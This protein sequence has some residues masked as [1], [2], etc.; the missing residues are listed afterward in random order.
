M[1]RSAETEEH[2]QLES[3]IRNAVHQISR[4]DMSMSGGAREEKSLRHALAVLSRLGCPDV[5]RAQGTEEWERTKGAFKWTPDLVAGPIIGNGHERD[6]YIDVFQPKGDQY[7]K[8]LAGNP[9]AAAVFTKAFSEHGQFT[10]AELGTDFGSFYGPI[11][12]KL[13][14]YSVTRSHSIMLGVIMY[15]HVSGNAYVGPVLAYWHSLFALDAAFGIERHCGKGTEGSTAQALQA[16]GRETIGVHPC[17]QNSQRD[18]T[19]ERKPR[20]RAR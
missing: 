9:Q 10:L 4:Y 7:V 16:A 12:K 18:R 8:P 6:F 5:R 14:R 15:F 11:N 3:T 17:D 2:N 19:A 1:R 13:E 20:D